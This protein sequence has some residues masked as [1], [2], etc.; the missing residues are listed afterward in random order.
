MI[1][2]HSD[3]ILMSPDP[4]GQVGRTPSADRRPPTAAASA[5]GLRRRGH[6]RTAGSPRA[7]AGG[8]KTRPTAAHASPPQF[9]GRARAGRG[10]LP[11]T[12][13]C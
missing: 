3:I 2:P 11:L 10:G 8:R 1:P 7:W 5:H 4:V 6:R 12:K 13:F 9:F